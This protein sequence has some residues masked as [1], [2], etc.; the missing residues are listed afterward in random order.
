[1]SSRFKP[2]RYTT[3]L[4]LKMTP[5]SALFEA[6]ESLVADR[7]LRKYQ[8]IGTGRLILKCF[9]QAKVG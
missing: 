9:P 8:V 6:F 5:K 1:M 3:F 4:V 7:S 2:I